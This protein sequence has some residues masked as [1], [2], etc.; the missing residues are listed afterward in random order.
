MKK[1]KLFLV[2]V[3]TLLA[4]LS[5]GATS[6]SAQTVVNTT[7]SGDLQVVDYSGKPPFKRRT[8]SSEDAA[9]FQRFEA[10]N[11]TVLVATSSPRRVGAPG[12]SLPRQVRS[13][14]RVPT[15][16]ISQ[17]ARFEE[18]T[19]SDSPR[20]WRGAPGKGRIRLGR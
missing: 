7:A 9:D 11:D 1:S 19:D 6:A 18:T 8:I 3:T 4:A 10:I 20:M 12:K 14:E 16:D 13:F 15:A 2:S 5:M 17:F